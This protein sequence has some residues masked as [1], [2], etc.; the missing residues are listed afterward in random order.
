LA[1][2]VT[3]L[4]SAEP[5]GALQSLIGPHAGAIVVVFNGVVCL[6]STD[7]VL[8]RLAA[9]AQDWDRAE[10]HLRDAVAAHDR[11]GAVLLAAAARS[12]F[13]RVLWSRS[14]PGD[15][16]RAAQLAGQ[17][18]AAF[19]S[20]GAHRLEALVPD[21]PSGG[22]SGGGDGGGGVGLSPREVEVLGQ[23]A[24]GRTNKEIAAELHISAATVQRH[25]IHVYRKL[26]VH[27]RSEAAAWAARHLGGPT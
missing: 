26:G 3:E 15:A 22:P 21:G 17:A 9:T 23:L 16:D 8:G 24:R 20:R 18:A 6:G 14:A 10:G 7:L 11:L 25:T 5:V 4:G 13:A 2:A 19:R 27:G 1:D 12:E